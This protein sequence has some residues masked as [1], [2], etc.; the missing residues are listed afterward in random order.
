MQKE[1]KNKK[2]KKEEIKD[3]YTFPD[4]GVVIEASSLSEAQEKYA[5][6]F[7]AKSEKEG[8]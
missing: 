1:Y 3:K 7:P 4:K 6:M 8:E 5:K 2:I